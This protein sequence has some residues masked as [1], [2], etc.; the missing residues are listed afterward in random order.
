MCRW[1]LVTVIFSTSCGFQSQVNPE[2]ADAAI[3]ADGPP[4]PDGAMSTSDNVAHVGSGDEYTGVGDL[5]IAAPITIDTGRMSFGMSLPPGVTFTPAKQDGG[6]PDLAILHVHRLNVHAT[7]RVIGSRP[8]IAI[9]DSLELTETINVPTPS[10]SCDTLAPPAPGLGSGSIELYART[11]ISISGYINTNTGGT[12]GPGGPGGPGGGGLGGG[13][14]PRVGGC[15]GDSLGT[16]VLQS[17]SIENSGRL[18]AQ[19]GGDAGANGGGPGQILMLYKTRVLP[20]VTT[21]T[22]ITQLY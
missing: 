18:S 12:G 17:P 4:Q 20:G 13:G 6:G 5:T 2:Q 11:R 9:A 19:S 14:E 7:V 10:S 22:A 3:I 21:P 16:I 8:L 1:I 15:Q